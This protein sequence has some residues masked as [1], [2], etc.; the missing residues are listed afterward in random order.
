MGAICLETF[1]RVELTDQDTSHQSFT[2]IFN[3]KE[4][5]I[6]NCREILSNSKST[7]QV[8]CSQFFICNGLL[9]LFQNYVFVDLW[10]ICKF[11][12]WIINIWFVLSLQFEWNIF[13]DNPQTVL[14]KYFADAVFC[15]GRLAGAVAGTGAGG[16]I[17]I[18]WV[19]TLTRILN[20][21]TWTSR[22]ISHNMLPAEEKLGKLS[23]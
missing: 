10:K 18:H 13:R 20:I 5:L 8:I 1:L 9:Q 4:S 17:F 7:Q 21:L 14:Q 12:Y 19:L 23:S 6:L 11:W 3:V 2:Q 16:L 15:V 22:A